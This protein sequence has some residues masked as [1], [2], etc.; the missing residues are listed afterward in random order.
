MQQRCCRWIRLSPAVLSFSVSDCE[1]QL[2]PRQGVLTRCREPVARCHRQ[3]VD[4]A[5]ELVLCKLEGEAPVLQGAGGIVGQ[6]DLH[7]K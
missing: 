1:E 7:R 4:D 6:S 2:G 3:A 5:D